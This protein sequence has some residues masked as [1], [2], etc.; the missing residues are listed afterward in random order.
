MGDVAINRELGT[1]RRGEHL[2]PRQGRQD[3]VQARAR[4][5]RQLR[6]PSRPLELAA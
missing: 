1:N 2:I 4:S 6:H 5:P 3:L